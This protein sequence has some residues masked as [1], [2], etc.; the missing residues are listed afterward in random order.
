MGENL[1]DVSIP[2]EEVQQDILNSKT[3]TKN[4]L[5]CCQEIEEVSDVQSVVP[6][7]AAMDVREKVKVLEQAK[8]KSLGD[9]MM[10]VKPRQRQRKNKKKGKTAGVE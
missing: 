6:V 7:F 5:K 10:E 2:M 1:K 3:T 9:F 8:Q 4:I